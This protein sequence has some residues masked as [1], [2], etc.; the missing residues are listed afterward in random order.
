MSEEQIPVEV[1]LVD[2]SEEIQQ[3]YRPIRVYMSE[4]P[5]ITFGYCFK[6]VGLWIAASALWSLMIGVVGGVIAL[7]FGILFGR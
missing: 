1:K 2:V 7:I 6:V 5:E 3:G 4:P